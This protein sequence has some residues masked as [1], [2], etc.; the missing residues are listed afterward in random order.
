MDITKRQMAKIARE[1]NKFTV[2][3]LR[4]DGM[5]VS[6]LDVLHAVRKNPGATQAKISQIIGLEKGAVANMA[7]KD[8]R[9]TAYGIFECSFGTF[10]F[11]GSW[12]M[13]VLYDWNISAMVI[14]SASAQL[15]AIP[16][17][18]YSSGLRKTEA[19]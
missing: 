17:Y 19:K 13:G 12:L 15:A 4:A 8:S 18:I 6:E 7:P 1:L 11:L 16:L 9:A 14:V 2:R 5:G 3:T 10:W